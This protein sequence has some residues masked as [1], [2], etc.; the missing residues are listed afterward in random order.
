[1]IMILIIGGAGYIGSHT[2]KLLTQK[3]HKTLVY[4]NLIYGHKEAVKWGEFILGDLNDI[5]QLRL[6]FGK[7]KIEAVMHFAA[8]AYVGESVENPEKYYINNVSNTLN[9]LQVMREFSCKY[10]I[11]S[12]TCATYGNPEYLP[13]DEKHPQ[14]PINPYGQSKFMLE[15]ILEDYS[16]AYDFKYVALR[17]FN[18][19][20]ADV[21]CEIGE[22]HNPETHLIP[23]IFDV[24][25]GKREDIKVFGTDYDTNDGSAVRDYIH[26]TDLANA[27]ILALEYLKNGGSSDIFNLGNGDGYSVFEVINKAKEITN[28]DIKV[29]LI[30]RRAGDPAKLIG[31]ATKAK[32]VLGWDPKL[33]DLGKILETAWEWHKCKK[34]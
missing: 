6:V 19:A 32:K 21:D 13:I 16:K 18:A 29:T 7:Y 20:G 8:F 9:L 12:S 25:I 23:L 15:K 17:Y 27:H 30:D 34:N 28:K 24:A 14:N 22:D 10:F 26:V 11:F 33:F 3:G 1:M 31:D 5:E 4:D 2:N